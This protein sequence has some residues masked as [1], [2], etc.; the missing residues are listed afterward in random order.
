[1]NEKAPEDHFTD[2]NI[3]NSRKFTINIDWLQ[4]HCCSEK[5]FQDDETPIFIIARTNQ[6]KVFR[7]IYTITY[8]KH[9]KVIATYAT[10]ALEQIMKDKHGVLKIDNFYLY[11]FSI[12]M[13]DFVEWFLRRMNLEFV[14]ITRL[15]IAYDF[16]EFSNKRNPEK[17]IKQFLNGQVVKLKK[18][19]FRVAG[20]HEKENTFNWISFGSKVSAITYKLYNKSLEM[21]EVT[22]KAH[23]YQEWEKSKLNVQKD[24]WR[25]EFTI[26][27][28]T[29]LLFNSGHQTNFHSTDTVNLEMI[30]G[31]FKSL[32]F[33][34][35]NFRVNDKNQIRKDRMKPIELLRFPDFITPITMKKIN[36]EMKDTSRSTKI[37][38]KKMNNM[39]D[40]LRGKDDEFAYDAKQLISKL[41]SIYHLETWAEKKGIDFENSNYVEDLNFND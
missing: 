9:N 35:M 29:N 21:K 7:N 39:Q 23:I 15:D 26:N 36:P 4:I 6:S 8:K 5:H 13:K 10:D 25:I 38:V 24:V 18:T 14:G 1:M 32:F 11:Y 33:R 37:F 19:K 20:I 3:E 12:R 31:L 41:I 2:F 28:N 34:Y 40:E 17:F 22:H 27:S 16:N 30:C